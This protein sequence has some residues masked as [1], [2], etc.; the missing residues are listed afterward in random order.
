MPPTVEVSPTP[1]AT[2]AAQKMV[3]KSNKVNVNTGELKELASLPK[4]STALARATISNRPYG[5]ISDLI[6]KVADYDWVAV[7]SRLEF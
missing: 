4:I 1:H 3:P 6:E 7:E 5:S 2:E